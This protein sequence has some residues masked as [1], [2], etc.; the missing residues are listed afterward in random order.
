M[1]VIFPQRAGSKRFYSQLIVNHLRKG[2]S[3]V[4]FI[5]VCWASSIAIALLRLQTQ[6]I[7]H[8]NNSVGM[9]DFSML[10]S[11][12][13]CWQ[14]SCCKDFKDMATS[15]G[16]Q[17]AS[18]HQE[19]IGAED[20]PNSGAIALSSEVPVQSNG[21]ARWIELFGNWL[22]NVDFIQI[23]PVKIAFRSTKP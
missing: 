12:Q 4:D 3:Q 15:S 21:R 1:L 9:L 22:N 19:V 6:L 7:Q 2:Y 18:E 16:V 11:Q 13:N 17:Q 14:H 8:A 23:G 5:L 20:E 10:Y